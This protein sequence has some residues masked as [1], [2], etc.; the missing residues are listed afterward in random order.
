MASSK[1]EFLFSP[2]NIGKVKLKNRIVKT[3]AQTCFFESGENRVGTLAKAFYGAVARGGA[4]L[5]ITETPAMEW[6]LLEEGDRRFRIDDDKYLKQLEE[7][8]AEVHKYGVPI[9]TQLYH[10]GPWSG[11]YTLA[12]QPVA[13]SAVTYPSP[14]DVHDE[15]LP[16]ALT[17][18][19]IDGLVERFA[20]GT[21]RL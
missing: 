17:I 20:S 2:T 10:R 8:A 1:Y 12:A 13:S 16:H 18:G 7:L 6:P 19:E 4:G 11:I 3:A 9:F 14:F 15:K 5:V 21:A